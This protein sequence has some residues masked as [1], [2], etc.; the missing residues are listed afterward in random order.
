MQNEDTLSRRDFQRL[1]GLTLASAALPV[2]LSSA[3]ADVFS[4][5]RLHFNENPL[6]LSPKARAAMNELLD[7][8]WQYPAESRRLLHD[9]VASLHG[10]DKSSILLG[11]GSSEILTLAAQTWVGSGRPLV[12]ASPTYDAMAQYA[13]PLGAEVKRVPLTK[14]FA[15]DIDRMLDAT[16]GKGLL[17]VCNPNNPTGTITPKAYVRKAIESAGRDAV[18]VVDEAYHHYVLSDDYESVVPLVAAHSNLVVLRTFSKI[19][20]MA[21]LRCGYAIA[22]PA[23]LAKMSERQSRNN[24]NVA[25]LLAARA[26]L[27]DRDWMIESKKTNAGTRAMVFA[28]L[29]EL[30]FETTA[31]EANFFMI[32]LGRDSR[33]VSTAMRDK[34]V[35]VGRPFPPMTEWLR[36]S[37][38]TRPQMERFLETFAAVV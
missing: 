9:A 35:L 38:G 19:Y 30:G 5:I 18:V 17:Y 33:E 28:R 26:S 22:Q 3:E 24:V 36:V 4:P 7:L 34:G 11:N 32:R 12:V 1:V 16:G 23:T 29:K 31:S 13:E 27:A 2:R 20:G 10:M 6:G 14:D 37:I 15:H 21:G 25:A 8:A